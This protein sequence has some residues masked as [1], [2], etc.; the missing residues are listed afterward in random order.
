MRSVAALFLTFILG[1]APARA[2]EATET[3]EAPKAAKANEAA[4]AE[5][6]KPQ[7]TE[8]L[9][10]TRLPNGLVVH[11]YRLAN[12][13]QILLVPDHSAPVFTFQKWFKVG[14]AGE[15]MDPRLKKTGLAHFFEHMMFRGT[16]KVPEGQFDARLTSAGSVGL[17][18]TTWLDRTNYFES[19]PKEKLEL[20]FQ[21]ESDR[22][23]NLVINEKAFKNELGAV[24]GEL[25]MRKDKPGSVA[26]EAVWD[27]AFDVHPYKYTVIGTEEELNSFTVDDAMYFYRTHYAPNNATMILLGDFDPK[28]AIAL[29][30]KYYG[31]Y[32]AK[33]LPEPEVPVEP[34][35]Q[36]ARTRELTH[37]LANSN[38]LYWGYR[39]PDG[40]SADIA[41]LEVIG[42]ILSTGD[43]SILEQDLV[44]EGHASSVGA[45]PGRNRYPGLFFVTIQMAPGKDDSKAHKS[46]EKALARF[47]DG[48]VNE[49]EIERARNQYLLGSY[50]ELLNQASIGSNLGE[51]LVTTDD[52][53]REFRLLEELKKVTAA[54][55]K[56]VANAYLVEKNSSFVRLTPAAKGDK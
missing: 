3:K 42:A 19:L 55:I 16:K 29:A 25:K 10:E 44:Q 34:P 53:L 52:Y 37:P 32:P 6:T 8:K 38:F 39:I 48:D 14:S 31:K 46:L 33:K 21:L 40:R 56:R 54:D 30:E 2:E 12:G 35:Q 49:A 4:K 13:M 22:M 11:E 5:K 15:K 27:L 51:S 47:R 1:L 26:Y 24:I 9:N 20:A 18:A 43:G 50:N 36:K 45:G 28:R 17:N 7:A 41:P 23:T